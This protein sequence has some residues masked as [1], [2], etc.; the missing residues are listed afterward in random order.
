MITDYQRSPRSGSSYPK[1]DQHCE[2][3]VAGPSGFIGVI[4]KFWQ[5]ICEE[6]DAIF[7]SVP[8]SF[9]L[10][11]LCMTKRVIDSRSGGHKS[12]VSD[13]KKALLTVY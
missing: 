9:H 13:S 6:H 12:Y 8:K 1:Y 11:L 5:R 3:D 2:S 4:Y 10:S 7:P